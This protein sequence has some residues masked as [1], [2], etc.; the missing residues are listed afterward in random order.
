MLL[1]AGLLLLA[2]PGVAS[3]P[4]K[5][6]GS[7]VGFVTD[8]GGVA[9]MG[10][11][12]LLL[13]R[14]EK[15]VQRA[16]TN[17]RGAFGFDALAPDSYS[18]RVSLASF[19]PALKQNILVQPGMR[20]FLS[21]NLASILSSIELIYSAP[22]QGALMSDDW[23]WVL[24]SDAATRPVLRF[25]GKIDISGP[26]EKRKTSEK[27]VFSQTEGLVKLSA[28]DS[29][30]S[31][32]FGDSPDLGTAFALATS[33]FGANRL[34]VSGNMG[35]AAQTGMPSAGFSTR[36]KR[37]SSAGISPEVQLTMRQLFLPLRAGVGLLSGQQGALPLRTMTASV[38]DREEL[39]D[40]LELEYGFALESV[41]YLDR[42]NYLSPYAR[43]RYWI[44]GVGEFHAAFS[45][46]VPPPDP[47]RAASGSELQ[48]DLAAL[49]ALPRVS[50]ENGRVR[51]QRAQNFELGYRRAWGGR[52]FS[53]GVFQENVSNAA[54]LIA[55]PAGL[56][57]DSG[58]LLP[59]L[60]SNSSVFNIGRYRSTG[61]TVSLSQKMTEGLE[62]TMAYGAGGVLRTE[63]RSMLTASPSELRSMIRS[64]R[65]QW[66][67]GKLAATLP[68][69]GTRVVSS[70]LWT[71]YRS[72]TPGHRYQ[73]QSMSPETGLNVAVRQPVPSFSRMPGRIE[74]TAEMRNLLAQGYLPIRTADGRNVYLIHSPRSVRGGLSFIF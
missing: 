63:G 25:R 64:A 62:V 68:G 35:Y 28:G 7:I 3:S 46:G 59:D 13:N 16:L 53:A 73:T 12:V 57:A 10:A 19:V 43:L 15:V 69:A 42:L 21:I 45:S 23:K 20:S 1:P 17:D 52:A 8:S 71:D 22:G 50:L 24:R 36:F 26:E 72:L 74:A 5:W 40:G 65:R 66:I 44:S 34:Q 30:V 47:V 41:S 70:Y 49:A 33:L 6:T 29:G 37:G 67:S 32:G 54:L 55:S 56:F 18:V 58:D 2:M 61:Y 27:G 31:S 14:Y 11:T 48:H 39:A 4:G 60:F 38:Q 9:Q 51:V